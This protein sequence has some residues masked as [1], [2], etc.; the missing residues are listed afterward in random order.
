[1]YHIIIP[2]T[3]MKSRKEPETHKTQTLNTYHTSE[4]EMELNNFSNTKSRSMS[5][6]S[7]RN[8]V[9]IYK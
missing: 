9:K 3:N 4:F 7:N 5:S 2:M 6:N 8:I 1:M